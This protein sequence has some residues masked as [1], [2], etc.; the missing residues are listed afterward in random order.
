MLDTLKGMISDL[1]VFLYGGFRSLPLVMA[2]TLLVLGLF[3]ANYAILFLLIGF[4]VLSPI[5]AAI[6]NVIVP[7]SCN[8]VYYIY[9]Y[10]QLKYTNGDFKEIDNMNWLEVQHFHKKSTDICKLSIPYLSSTTPASKDMETIVSSPW[11]A[12]MSFFIGYVIHNAIQL[13][14]VDTSPDMNVVTNSSSADTNVKVNNRKT[15][16]MSAL[17]STAVIGIIILALRAYGGCEGFIGFILTSVVFGAGGY[18]WY[19]LLSDLGQDRLSDI[20]GIANRILPPSA[21]QN[22][23]IACVPIPAS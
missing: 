7:F 17:I 16:A 6:I 23:P 21:I 19:T 3:T 20:F 13:Y 22:G 15:Q 10:I 14:I 18:F 5:G 12:M 2:G 11:M 4:L 8:L 1:H 9:K